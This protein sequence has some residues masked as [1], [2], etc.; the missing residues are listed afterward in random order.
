M[1]TSDKYIEPL[2]AVYKKSI[3]DAMND[4]LAKGERKVR[5][6]FE[7]CNV[8]FMDVPDAVALENLNTMEEYKTYAGSESNSL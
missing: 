4:V 7:H 8:K 6:A 1:P 3:V 2:F 5:A